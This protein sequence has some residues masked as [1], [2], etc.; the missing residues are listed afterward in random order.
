MA[1]GESGATF[2]AFED[3]FK[4][5]ILIIGNRVDSV[6][7]RL[8]ENKNNDLDFHAGNHLSQ[9]MTA[10]SPDVYWKNSP[11]D[12]IKIVRSIG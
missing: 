12:V 4:G 6:Y 11:E 3:L 2:I 9:F 1:S 10:P 5:S 8:H 7:E